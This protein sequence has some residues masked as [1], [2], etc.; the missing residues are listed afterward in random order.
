M[1]YGRLKLGHQCYETPLGL[2]AHTL[3]VACVA[4]LPKHEISIFR[5]SNLQSLGR[6]TLQT[7]KPSKTFRKVLKTVV[8]SYILCLHLKI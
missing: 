2:R 5:A 7:L 4:S 1:S 6:A 8:Y 3:E